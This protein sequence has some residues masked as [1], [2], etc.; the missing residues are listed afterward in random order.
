MASTAVGEA[1]SSSTPP[2]TRSCTYHVFL[3]F[4]GEDTRAGFISHLY[5][6]LDRKGITIYKDDINLPQSEAISNEL[7]RAIEDSMFAV[8]VL[9]PNYASSTWCLDELQKIVEYKN[10]L[11]LQIVPVFYG[12]EPSDVR[13]QIRTFEDAFRNHEGRLGGDSEKVKRWREAL[14]QVPYRQDEA[15][16]VESIA[17]HI[18]TKLF[19]K[20][21]PSDE[22]LVGIASKVEEVIKLAD[23]RV[24]DVRF[25]GIWG[26][27]GIGKTTIAHAV[28]KSM[29]DNEFKVCCF[30][31]II[32]E[33]CKKKGL[34]Q[35]QMD[36]LAQCHI[37]CKL[38]NENQGREVIKNALCK[39]K[40]LLV[41]DDASDISQLDNL[42][43]KRGYLEISQE[44]VE[45]SGCLPLALKYL[46]SWRCM[47]CYNIVSQSP[48][49]GSE[50][51]RLWSA[52]HINRVLKQNKV[53][54]ETESIVIKFCGDGLDVRGRSL[55]FSSNMCKLKLLILDGVT[56]H[57]IS[58]IPTSLKVLRWTECPMESLPLKEDEH[59]EL[60]EIDL[61]YSKI[62]HVWHGKKVN[63][64]KISRK[65]KTL[66]S[67]RVQAAEAKARSSGAP[68]LEKLHVSC[69]CELNDIHSSLAV[70]KSLV[71]LNLTE[72]P[73]LRTLAVGK[74]EMSSLRELDLSQC[75]N[76][77][78]LTEFGECMTKLACL[79]LCDTPIER[80]P[81]TTST[82]CLKSLSELHLSICRKHC[83]FEA[84]CMP[85]R[86]NPGCKSCSAC[87][88][89]SS[90][91]N[92][93]GLTTLRLWGCQSPTCLNDSVSD[94][95]PNLI[96]LLLSLKSQT[97]L[98]TLQ[99]F[100]C[101]PKSRDLTTLDIGEL[102]SLTDLDL[103][104]NKFARVPISIYNHPKLRRLKLDN[105]HNLEV[106][107]ELPP[108]LRELHA[109]DCGS[110]DPSSFGIILK[111]CSAFAAKAASKR[112]DGDDLLQMQMLT[113]GKKIPSWFDHLGE[114]N[115]VLVP[116]PG[117]EGNTIALALCF[118][119]RGNWNSFPALPSLT[120]NGREFLGNNSLIT[121]KE[122]EH[123]QLYFI[124]CRRYCFSRLLFRDQDN[125]FQMSFP[126]DRDIQVQRCGS[127]WV[128]RE[129]IET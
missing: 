51:S 91:G 23:I 116:F 12:M 93:G 39:K 45:H 57:I 80:L 16:I 24:N 73:K 101:F 2:P 113:T 63:L 104:Y 111:A 43:G 117:N 96:E 89:L 69:C 76:L 52:N 88:S 19:P 115:V 85:L 83:T 30:L 27:G 61:S 81:T 26:M 109:R 121:V 41:L 87:G 124:L 56:A 25:I 14:I 58:N 95:C 65:A 15:T 102:E 92:L 72:Y 13:H 44:I 118:R 123:S 122:A 100:Q 119:F 107:P 48:N 86:T 42:A 62:K 71:E 33:N 10:N 20:L 21:P 50:L 94:E 126:G 47:T 55:V 34:V 79:S 129:D 105:C 82:G 31:E 6:A 78:K 1:S 3:S 75:V 90:L 125:R 127:R 11:G 112:R 5:A 29:E 99:L 110:L 120:C 108:S 22:K 54:K 7:L 114:D 38:D 40:V 9:S 36:V 106:L 67:V 84:T 49:D 70:H 4:R 60:V 18:H 64:F 35:V 37:K 103:S 17:Q 74:L 68:N 46:I 53:V 28:Y 128:Y 77:K 32:R 98:T 66:R 59:Y 97:R 8:V